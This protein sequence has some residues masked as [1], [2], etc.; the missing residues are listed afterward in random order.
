MILQAKSVTSLF[1][2]AAIS[3]ICQILRH[4]PFGSSSRRRWCPVNSG[5]LS[6]SR[7]S[8]RPRGC[9][10]DA[11]RISVSRCFETEQYRISVVSRQSDG[12]PRNS[13]KCPARRAIVARRDRMQNG[14]GG[15]CHGRRS[16][17]WIV[18]SKRA[19][20]RGLGH[21]FFAG[22]RSSQYAFGDIRVPT[23]SADEPIRDRQV[24]SSR[25][26]PRIST[27]ALPRAL[28]RF[29]ASASR[30]IRTARTCLFVPR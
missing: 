4:G 21:H 10:P 27:R 29:L 3:A 16:P 11:L 2:N 8:P 7:R 22:D 5:Y 1:L 14:L 13:L 17:V 9:I 26:P 25:R 12:P 6:E 18:L 28:V 20:P 19:S 30:A 23:A 15:D 24:L